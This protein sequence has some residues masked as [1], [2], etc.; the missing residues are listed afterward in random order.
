MVIERVRAIIKEY[1]EESIRPMLDKNSPVSIFIPC[2]NDYVEVAGAVTQFIDGKQ[3]LRLVCRTSI[4]TE[5]LMN[6]A[7]LQVY[8][9]RHAVPF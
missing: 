2:L 9:D 3:Y 6:P 7:D 1:T 5:I 4:G 8:F